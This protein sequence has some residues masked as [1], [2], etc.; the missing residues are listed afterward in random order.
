MPEADPLADV[1]KQAAKDWG[2]GSPQ[3][4]ACDFF[5]VETAWLQRLHVLFFI[6]M[7]SR[8]VHLAGIAA[9][10]TAEWVAQQARNLAWKLQDGALKAKFLLRDRDSKFTAGFDQIFGSEGVKV[11]K[12][13]FRSPRANSICERF[14]GTCRREVLDHLLIFSARH[15]E[16]VIKEFL[17]HYHEARPHQSLEQRCPDVDPVLVPLPVGGEIVRHDRLGGLLHEYSWAV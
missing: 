1:E 17:V 16:A 12:L 14:V 3:S 2:L 6:E 13:P 5:T 9:S 4:L 15:L 8:K 7:A 10:P 11:V